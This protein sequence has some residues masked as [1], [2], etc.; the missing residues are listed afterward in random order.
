MSKYSIELRT[1]V[2]DP[3]FD[4]F[5]FEY[6]FYTDDFNVRKTFEQKFIDHFYFD[7]IGSETV[8]RFKW[9]LK[10]KLNV[11]MPYYRQLYETELKAKDINFLLNKDLREEY[12]RTLSSDSDEKI[13]TNATTS[14]NTNSTANSKVSNIDNGVSAVNLNPG[15]LTGVSQDT[16]QTTNAFNSNNNVKRNTQGE[17]TERTVTTSQGNIGITSSAELLKKWREVLINIDQMILNECK[18]LFMLV[19]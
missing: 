10:S 14:N 1:L 3:L 5:D 11:I 15:N 7:E 2:S 8:A 9:M 17:I 16:N 19:Y 12:E 4:L 6:T 13:D 18:D